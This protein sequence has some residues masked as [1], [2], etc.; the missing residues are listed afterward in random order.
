[1]DD[2]FWGGGGQLPGSSP[3]GIFLSYRRQDAAP[4]ARMLKEKFSGR[5]PDTQVFMDLDSIEAGV[6]FAEVI[7]QAVRSSAVLVALIGPQWATLTD[8]QGR[9]RLDAP[10]DYVR[11]EIRT[12]LD[13]DVRVIPVLVDG[14]KPPRQEQLPKR[15]HK[16]ARLNAL[17]LSLDHY[18]YDAKRLL[19]LIQRVLTEAPGG[20]VAAREPLFALPTPLCALI[21]ASPAKPAR[22]DRT[23]AA[24]LFADAERIARSITDQGEKA[25]ALSSVAKA[26]AATSP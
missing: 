15:L 8:E 2:P 5:F 11:F 12:A 13:R 1:M 14:A 26:L 20:R 4:Y 17:E 9:R 3:R 18:E 23:R 10:H 16:L 7:G 21:T 22:D 6:D 25:L 19:D 24:R